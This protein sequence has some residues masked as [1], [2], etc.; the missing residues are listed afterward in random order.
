MNYLFLAGFYY[1]IIIKISLG[2]NY[3]GKMEFNKVMRYL[4][5]RKILGMIMSVNLKLVLRPGANSLLKNVVPQNL[6]VTQ[7]KYG[8]RLALK[9]GHQTRVWREKSLMIR[10]PQTSLLVSQLVFGAQQVRR[11]KRNR[12]QKFQL[13]VLIR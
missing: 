13:S 7:K 2:M 9:T 8:M 11:K 6:S 4:D 1:R 12:P 5:G 10:Q 3:R